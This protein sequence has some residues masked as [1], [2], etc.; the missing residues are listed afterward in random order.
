MT[1]TAEFG[2]RLQLK[3]VFPGLIFGA[4]GQALLAMPFDV[5]RYQYANAVRVGLA[6]RS[7]LASAKLERAIDRLELLILGPLARQR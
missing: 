5:V 6:Q 1:M 4:A 2:A 7:M 3:T